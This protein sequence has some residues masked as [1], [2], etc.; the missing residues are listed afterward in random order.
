MKENFSE[1]SLDEPFLRTE[2]RFGFT[3]QP[4]ENG[5]IELIK[6]HPDL[7]DE[8]YEN[9]DGANLNNEWLKSVN[10]IPIDQISEASEENIY[11]G[12][13]IV[14]ETDGY[15]HKFVLKKKEYSSIL[16]DDVVLHVDDVSEIDTKTFSFD[17]NFKTT[18]T[19]RDERLIPIMNSIQAASPE[20]DG[21]GFFCKIHLPP[22]LEKGFFT[23]SIIVDNFE[24]KIDQTKTDLWIYFDAYSSLCEEFFECSKKEEGKGIAYYELRKN[25]IGSISD[26]FLMEKIPFYE[27]LLRYTILP[28]V[29]ENQA[30]AL[31]LN[32]TEFGNKFLESS[33]RNLYRPDWEFKS[34]DTNHSF[35]LDR[36]TEQYVPILM[37][38][39]EI[40]RKGAYF[41]YKLVLPII[42][43]IALSWLVFFIDVRELESRL[44]ISIVCFLSLIAYNFVVDDTL[45]KLGY[46]TFIDVYFNFLRFS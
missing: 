41:I 15:E 16:I 44:T 36:H 46:L 35:E 2:K 4:Y 3:Q 39:F 19:W 7:S 12:D 32:V 1:L 21:A 13:T 18:L 20:P 30:S 11:S 22:L 45:P 28:D 38:D 34:Y 26:I 29:L 43:L 17:T 33:A 14:I 40:E 42:F 9:F 6:I 25:H 8:I 27:Q 37:F 24:T 5:S 23:P 31:D 10:G